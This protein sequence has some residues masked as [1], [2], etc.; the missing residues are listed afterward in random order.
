MKE[1]RSGLYLF[2]PLQLTK[3]PLKALMHVVKLGEKAKKKK[4]KVIQS[5]VTASM[6]SISRSH[7]PAAFAPSHYCFHYTLLFPTCVTKFYN[8]H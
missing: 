6:S 5:S 8:F 1:E 3:D 7:L 2:P 4:K